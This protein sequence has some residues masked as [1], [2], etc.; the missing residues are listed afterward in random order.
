MG[1]KDA[2]AAQLPVDQYRK[3]IGQ[4]Q[5]KRASKSMKEQRSADEQL[6]SRSLV[7]D[8]LL[9]LAGLLLLLVGLYCSLYYYI[10]RQGSSAKGASSTSQQ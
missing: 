1:R 3:K 9:P 2:M 10:D 4:S 5:Q 8:V 6:K 7:S